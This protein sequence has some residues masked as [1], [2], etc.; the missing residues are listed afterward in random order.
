MAEPEN[1]VL[2]ILREMRGEISEFRKSVDTRFDSVDGRFDAVEARLEAVET[3]TDGLA[4]LL[5]SAFG[6][7]SHDVSA[8][9]E[10]VDAL[11][12]ARGR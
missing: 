10:R 9:S 11:E 4:V 6:Q 3:K 5:A 1:L 2:S 7:L 8:L 12:P